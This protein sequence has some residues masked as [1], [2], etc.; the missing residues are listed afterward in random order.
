[1][2]GCERVKDFL[3]GTEA[4]FKVVSLAAYALCCYAAVFL[5]KSLWLQDEVT[6][7]DSSESESS[8]FC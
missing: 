1:M 3:T 5:R 8:G 2:E 4:C 6:N 7:D